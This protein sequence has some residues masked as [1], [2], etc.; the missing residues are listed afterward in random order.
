MG[1]W[2]AAAA[3]SA[4]GSPQSSSVPA[5]AGSPEIRAAIIA[6]AENHNVDPSLLLAIASRESGMNPN[7]PHKPGDGYGMMQVLDSTFA[8]YGTGNINDFNDNLNAAAN[9]LSVLQKQ[10]GGNEYQMAKHYNGSGTKAEEY[11]TDVMK[12]T[13]QFS[14]SITVN[15]YAQ[16]NASPHDI[17]QIAVDKLKDFQRTEH[18]REIVQSG[19]YGPY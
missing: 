11:A 8:N 13:Q 19:A 16:T 1:A 3:G 6:A 9:Y 17:A 5:G 18:Q 10:Y 7:A 12:R 4:K 15:V 14:Q 2:M